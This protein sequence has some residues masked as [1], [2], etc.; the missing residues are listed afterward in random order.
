MIWI[1][2]EELCPRH[3]PRE[4]RTEID[5]ELSHVGGDQP[6]PEPTVF[7]QPFEAFLRVA[8]ASGDRV[9]VSFSGKGPEI[10]RAEPLGLCLHD[11]DLAV[12]TQAI[13]DSEVS[14][15]PVGQVAAVKEIFHYFALA[16]E[17]RATHTSMPCPGTQ[18][19]TTTIQ[20]GGEIL[21]VYVQAYWPAE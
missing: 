7:K 9:R 8:S 15:L 19:L 16:L 14:D 12:V 1:G 18:M 6:E 10:V 2:K 4:A 13:R 17:M 21:V 3:I 20:V 5:A 11:H